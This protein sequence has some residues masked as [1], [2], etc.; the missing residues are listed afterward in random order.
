MFVDGMRCGLEAGTNTW[1]A[2]IWKQEATN[3]FY[4]STSAENGG[5]TGLKKS[6]SR[7][8]LDTFFASSAH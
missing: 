8:F 3:R 1:S 2:H 7:F 6:S 5:L 4:P